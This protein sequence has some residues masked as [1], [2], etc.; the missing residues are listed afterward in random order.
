MS[1]SHELEYNVPA[2]PRAGLS[3]LIT[4]CEPRGVQ[5]WTLVRTQHGGCVMQCPAGHAAPPV[6][7]TGLPGEGAPIYT[8]GNSSIKL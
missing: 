4:A 1:Y 5:A 8:G 3:A 2:Q 6:V 7:T